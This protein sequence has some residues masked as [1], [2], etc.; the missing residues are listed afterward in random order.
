[1][2]RARELASSLD[3][4]IKAVLVMIGNPRLGIMSKQPGSGARRCGK[5]LYEVDKAVAPPN[6][7][8][9]EVGSVWAQVLD[10]GDEDV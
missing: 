4:T 5:P 10:V 9:Y 2:P 3:E 1:M 7:G 6:T 8:D